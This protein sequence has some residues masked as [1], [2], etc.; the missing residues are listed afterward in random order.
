MILS[1][2][3]VVTECVMNVLMRGKRVM[4]KFSKVTVIRSVNQSKEIKIHQ[5]IL[6]GFYALVECQCVI[7]QGK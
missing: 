5:T 3:L 1:R 4:G 2:H 7:V 6:M